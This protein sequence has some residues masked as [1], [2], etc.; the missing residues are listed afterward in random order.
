[1]AFVVSTLFWR[2][3]RLLCSWPIS[4]HSSGHGLVDAAACMLCPFRRKHFAGS[5]ALV[6]DKNTVEDGNYF[7]GVIFCGWK[8]LSWWMR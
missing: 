1:M 7:F 2:E 4:G 5:F 3:V 8:L 6:Q